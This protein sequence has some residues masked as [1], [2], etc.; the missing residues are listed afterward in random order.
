M[1]IETVVREYEIRRT[2]TARVRYEECFPLCFFEPV[3]LFTSGQGRICPSSDALSI[4]MRLYEIFEYRQILTGN[5]DLYSRVSRTRQE[6]TLA[7]GDTGLAALQE[8]SIK[9]SFISA[10]NPVLPCGYS[11]LP[12]H[13][14]FTEERQSLLAKNY[15]NHARHWCC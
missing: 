9:V 14:V 2:K 5:N 6:A 15:I 8:I 1:F 3:L 7:W 10:Q 11:N 13:R 4:I 12:T